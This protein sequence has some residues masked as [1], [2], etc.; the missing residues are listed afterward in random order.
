MHQDD[1][2]ACAVR[3]VRAV[4][5]ENDFPLL[6]LVVLGTAGDLVPAN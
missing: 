2:P 3:G 1:G 6:A 5:E 4:G